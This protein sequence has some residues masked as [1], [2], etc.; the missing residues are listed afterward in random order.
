MAAPIISISSDLSKETDSIVAPKEGTVSILSPTRVL[1]LVD[2]SSSFDSDPSEDSL[3]PALDLPLVSPFLCSDDSEANKFSLVPN[4]APPNIHQR[5]ATLIRPGEAIPFDRPYHTHLNGPHKFLTAR[6]RVGPILAHRLAWRR[7]SHHLS[8]HHSSPDSS[9]S[10][11]PSDHS[12]SVHTPPDTTDAD[13]STPPRLVHRSL[14]KTLRRSEAFRRWRSTPLS[15]PYPSTTSESCLGS[16]SERSLDSPT[17]SSGPSRK[18]CRS[19]AASVPSPTHDSRSIAPT[20]ADLLPP[21][22]R[23]RDSYSPEDSGEE[24]MKEMEMVEMEIAEM[25]IVEMEIQ[26]I[27]VE[28]TEGVVGLISVLTWWNSHKRTI[29]AE[30]AFAMSWRELMKLMNKVYCPRNEIQ[31]MESELWNLTVKNNDLAAYT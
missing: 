12:L 25:E 27:M 17:P 4:V 24:Q 11:S 13:S 16:S 30:A 22:K 19:P 8:D 20:P 31:K 26:M 28:G 2:Y 18:R 29:G 10:S 21:C 5:L 1:D 3:P 7:V 9:S 23:F 15:T 14:A 6:K